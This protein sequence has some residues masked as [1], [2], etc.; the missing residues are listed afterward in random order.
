MLPCFKKYIGLVHH[1][2]MEHLK[3]FTKK[4]KEL[5]Q[6]G[7]VFRYN[8]RLMKGP[9]VCLGQT[10]AEACKTRQNKKEKNRKELA[11]GTDYYS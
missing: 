8:E 3:L 4:K 9:H 7:G 10:N 1:I 5:R 6:V 2:L 11:A